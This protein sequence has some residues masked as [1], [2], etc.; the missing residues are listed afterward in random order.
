MKFHGFRVSH[1]K[2]IECVL[3]D[4]SCKDV[5]S[6]CDAHAQKKSWAMASSFYLTTS[7][8]RNVGVTEY[9]MA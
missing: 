6:G 4:I 3:T 9:R 1:S 5:G 8:N 7:S 2:V